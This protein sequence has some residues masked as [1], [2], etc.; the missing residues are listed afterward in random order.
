MMPKKV[1]FKELEERE[2]EANIANPGCISH[3]T[4]TFSKPILTTAPA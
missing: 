3:I 1:F 2:K 4:D